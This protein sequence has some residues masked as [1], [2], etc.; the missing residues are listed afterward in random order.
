M[1]ERIIASIYSAIDEINEQLDSEEKL[2]KSIDTI[3]F[4]TES[5]LDSLGLINL[6]TGIEINIEDEFNLT[7]TLADERAMS[8]EN[9][10][11]KSV[12]S[13][14]SYIKLLLEELKSD[15]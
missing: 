1:E 12:K 15:K 13:L 8:Q 2:E 7:I 14:A 9:T 5:K 3:I 6:I 10:P 11:F 4:G